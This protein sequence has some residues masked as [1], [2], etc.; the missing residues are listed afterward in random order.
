MMPDSS[1]NKDTRH[2]GSRLLLLAP[3]CYG[4]WGPEAI[5]NAKFARALSRSGYDVTVLSADFGGR[6]ALY[7]PGAVEACRGTESKWIAIPT[8]NGK[9]VSNALLHLKAALASGHAYAG[10]G[11]AGLAIPLAKRLHESRP[12]DLVISRNSPAEIVGMY[13]SKQWG[14]PWIANWN[15]PYPEEKYPPPYSGGASTQLN[16]RRSRLL[17]EICEHASWHT[18]PCRELLDYCSE[19]FP[20]D[21]RNRASVLPHIVEAAIPATRPN[22]KPEMVFL[23][24]GSLGPHRRLGPLLEGFDRFLQTAGRESALARLRLVGHIPHGS[25]APWRLSPRARARV[26]FAGSKSYVDTKMELREASV[27]VI[28]EADLERG[29]FLPSKVAD[30]LE[31]GL[32]VFSVSPRNGVMATLL[33]EYGGGMCADVRNPEEIAS[34]FGRLYEYWERG[35]L[36]RQICPRRL[37]GR[38][39]SD[40]VMKVFEEV[41]SR[42]WIE[43]NQESD[44][45]D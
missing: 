25:E 34:A 4:E 27:G 2:G 1:P 29:I 18:F 21:L 13:F 24:A 37:A 44:A 38:F 9:T 30:Y 6:K 7:Q 11:W 45:G 15:D 10:M 28:L 39:S 33:R 32:P 35:E 26:D 16:G 43:S 22:T 19:Y 14:L 20:T 3:A 12:F 8:P 36:D 5:V 31:A 23:H 40:Q 41:L 17:N 42:I